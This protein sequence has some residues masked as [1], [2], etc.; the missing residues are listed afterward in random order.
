MHLGLVICSQSDF[1]ASCHPMGRKKYKFQTRWLSRYTP[2]IDSESSGSTVISSTIC[3]DP[4]PLF[5]PRRDVKSA[6]IIYKRTRSSC[7]L[8]RSSIC[9]QCQ[10]PFLSRSHLR[11][12]SSA[13][14]PFCFSSCID[15]AEHPLSPY[16][17]PLVRA[18]S[19]SLGVS[20]PTLSFTH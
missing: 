11:M 4:R 8:P 6:K 20:V 1:A 12:W 5:R 14:L 10:T 16:P 3:N 15:D 17:I 19:L 18:P 7:V 2:C 9:T 13:P